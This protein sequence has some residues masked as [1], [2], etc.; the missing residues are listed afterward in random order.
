MTTSTTMRRWIREKKLRF[1]NKWIVSF[2]II[3]SIF[4]RCIRDEAFYSFFVVAVSRGHKGNLRIHMRMQVLR[5]RALIKVPCTRHTE[6][7]WLD[8]KHGTLQRTWHRFRCTRGSGDACCWLYAYSTHIAQCAHNATINSSSA[9]PTC[10]TSIAVLQL[11]Q[12]LVMCEIRHETLIAHTKQVLLLRIWL[13]TNDLIASN[14]MSGK[15]LMSHSRCRE[16][17]AQR[18]CVC[19]CNHNH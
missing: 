1:I 5:A 2:S 13:K 7:T 12:S 4:A 8:S 14:E 3:I 17:I 16:N 11:T 10:N 19:V 6:V 15:I 9:L 18:M